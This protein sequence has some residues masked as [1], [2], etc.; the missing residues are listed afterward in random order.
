MEIKNE[1]FPTKLCFPCT[2]VVL[3]ASNM[4][5]TEFVL[6]II[7]NREKVFASDVKLVYYVCSSFQSRFKEIENLDP[8]IIFITSL[9]QLPDDI[10][11]FTLIVYD[12]KL[13]DFQ[14]NKAE[15]I[16]LTN[17]FIGKARHGNI[18][19]I[20]ILQTLVGT[21][22]RSIASNATYT[23]VFSS[24]RNKTE[25]LY[26]SREFGLWGVSFITSVLKDISNKPFEYILFDGTPCMPEKYRIRNFVYLKPN[27]KIYFLKE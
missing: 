13:V 21:G 23:I 12:D 2:M 1:V 25:L 11:E 27:S 3:G 17:M 18:G 24:S 16:H 4:G 8:S 14:N 10:P 6:D 26:L 7:T 20:L 15:R 5:K 19:C 9:A 22:L